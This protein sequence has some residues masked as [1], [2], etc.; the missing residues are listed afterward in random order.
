MSVCGPCHDAICDIYP[1][2]EAIYPERETTV[3]YP[4]F[5][6]GAGG[7]CWICIKHAGFLEHHYPAVYE[8]WLK[9]EL[10]VTVQAD[11]A[12]LEQ[13]AQ[14]RTRHSSSNET[15]P[16]DSRGRQNMEVRQLIIFRNHGGDENR[17]RRSIDTSCLPRVFQQ[18]IEVTRSLQIRYL[19]IDSLC[20]MQDIA[21]GDWEAEA[22]KMGDVYANSFLNLPAS[23]TAGE[24][25]NPSIFSPE[26]W[27]HVLPSELVLEN[28]KELRSNLFIDGDLWNDEVGESPLMERGWVF[29]ERFL[30]PRVLHFG[31][32]QLAGECNGGGALQMFPTGLPPRFEDNYKKDVCWPIMRPINTLSS[33]EFCSRWHDI[34]TAY[35]AG[36]L[37]FNTDKL[38]AFAGIAKIIQSLGSDEYIAGTWKSTIIADLAW[39]VYKANGRLPSGHQA[40]HRAPSWSWLSSD[41]QIC[42]H[43]YPSAHHKQEYFVASWKLRQERQP[44]LRC[45]VQTASSSYKGLFSPSIP[46]SGITWK[47]NPLR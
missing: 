28:D 1:K 20:I 46:P 3:T 29:Q 9:H 39:W 37:T 47:S 18:A 16:F 24:D 6:P 38:I 43:P 42:F 23:Y 13:E 17:F 11:F 15:L 33:E 21:C 35:S 27:N 31:M 40:A 25:E 4:S 45:L 36:H 44:G 32:R 34:V 2:V 10:L 22:L 41:R 7:K 19:W 26:S 8:R 12:S 30:A 14:P 5:D